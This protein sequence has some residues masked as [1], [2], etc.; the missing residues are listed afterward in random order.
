[1]SSMIGAIARNVLDNTDISAYT[2]FKRITDTD[3]WSEQGRVMKMTR[4]LASICQSFKIVKVVTAKEVLSQAW[5]LSTAENPSL[6]GMVR[7]IL[8]NQ[9]NTNSVLDDNSSGFH[10][11]DS[12]SSVLFQIVD[13]NYVAELKQPIKTILSQCLEF[14]LLEELREEEIIYEHIKNAVRQLEPQSPYPFSDALNQSKVDTNGNTEASKK[15][16]NPTNSFNFRGLIRYTTDKYNEDIKNMVLGKRNS[17][18]LVSPWNAVWLVLNE[19]DLDLTNLKTR[20]LANDMEKLKQ[21]MSKQ[22]DFYLSAQKR[23]MEDLYV[24]SV[25]R[26]FLPP[27]AVEY[28]SQPQHDPQLLALIYNVENVVPYGIC[29]DWTDFENNTTKK[30]VFDLLD[31]IHLKVRE[32]V[33]GYR[34]ELE[35]VLMDSSSTVLHILKDGNQIR[36]IVKMGIEGGIDAIKEK[37]KE[38][39][40]PTQL[41]TGTLPLVISWM[42]QTEL[43]HVVNLNSAYKPMVYALFPMLFASVSS[44]ERRISNGLFVSLKRIGLTT[45]KSVH[46]LTYTN[47]EI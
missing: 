18:A 39:F 10:Q 1:M 26:G 28:S 11:T 36:N 41:A 4:L 47:K 20:Y 25:V 13:D 42:L 40:T 6:S 5:A 29:I 14:A 37:V 31:A 35:H 9:I 24:L 3:R 34:K 32:I 2:L 12:A 38:W 8:D 21:N 7:E 22:K 46:A 30:V 15:Q 33:Q 44:I 23:E 17:D 43:M 27:R 19:S 45:E 16:T